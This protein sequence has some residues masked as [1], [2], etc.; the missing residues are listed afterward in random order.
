[1][2][3]GLVNAPFYFYKLIARVL[4]GSEL[5]VVLY[6]DNIAVFSPTWERYVKDT[7]DIGYLRKAGLTVKPSKFVLPQDSVTFLGHEVRSGKRSPT[8]FKIKSVQVSNTHD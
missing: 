6:I 3:F 2:I 4:R 7:Y 1:M 5:Y 8:E